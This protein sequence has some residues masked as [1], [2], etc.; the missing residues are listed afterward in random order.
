MQHLQRQQHTRHTR[1]SRLRW[2][3]VTGLLLFI[4]VCVIVLITSL[5]IPFRSRSIE[6]A[7]SRQMA[8]LSEYVVIPNITKEVEVLVAVF[9]RFNGR[10]IESFVSARRDHY[11]KSGEQSADAWR[12]YWGQ[13]F[14]IF[15]YVKRLMAAFNDTIYRRLKSQRFSC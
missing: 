14:S 2:I 4:S 15:V 11:F 5:K 7:E 10:F 12:F 8:L 3:A 13:R 1:R 6:I 9:Y